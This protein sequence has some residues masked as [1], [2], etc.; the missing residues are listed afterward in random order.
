MAIRDPQGTRS[1]FE[2][3]QVSSPCYM[4]DCGEVL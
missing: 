3:E 4:G 1:Q 2:K